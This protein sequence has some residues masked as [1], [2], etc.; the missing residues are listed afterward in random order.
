M[1]IIATIVFA[2]VFS[3]AQ[4]A[5]VVSWNDFGP[6]ELRSELFEITRP[7]LVTLQGTGVKVNWDDW[8]TSRDNALAYGWILNLETREPVWSMSREMSPSKTRGSAIRRIDGKVNLPA[9]KYAVYYFCGIDKGEN[10]YFDSDGD[11][12][13][14]D[15]LKRIFKDKDSYRVSEKDRRKLYFT[16]TAER[17]SFRPIAADPLESR[18]ALSITTPRNSSFKSHV[19]RLSEPAT[20]TV[21]AIGEYDQSARQMADGGYIQDM[22][23]RKKVWELDYRGSEHAGG[24]EKNRKYFGKVSLPAGEYQLVYATDDSHTFGRWNAAPPYDPEFWGVTILADGDARRKIAAVEPSK[25]PV[26]VQFLRVGDNELLSTGFTLDKAMDLRVYCIGEYSGG[27]HSFA[28]YGLI[29]GA[30]SG[31][32]AWDMTYSNTEPA[33]GASKN[34]MFDG[35]VHFPAGDYT[36]RYVSDGSHSYNHW[37]STAPYDQEHW[38]IVVAGIPG[39]FDSKAVRPFSGEARSKNVLVKMVGLRDDD[40][41]EQSFRLAKTTSLRIY[42]I[43]EG[44][45]DEM[46]DYGWIENNETGRTVWEMTWRN[47]LPAGGASKNRMCDDVVILPPGSYT[48]RY[49]TDGSHS[50]GDW[51]A[52]PPR[53]PFNWGITIS[54]AQ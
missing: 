5:S 15:G 2:F 35:I 38:G 42:A 27:D 46:Y 19:F 31:K 49:E 51:N 36:V 47:T 11:R 53:D 30:S 34:R 41:R 44:G 29:E 50:T 4:E 16:V 48:V 43:G 37:N 3:E 12:G 54:L 21:Y 18:A 33:G 6:D 10:W 39:S 9:G 25:E 23:S 8:R 28:D 7:T 32:R 17:G 26:I 13:I 22:R 20:L 45:R 1:G 52:A 40:E 14:F 24:A